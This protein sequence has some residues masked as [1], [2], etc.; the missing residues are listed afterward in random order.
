MRVQALSFLLGAAIFQQTSAQSG[1]CTSE[2]PTSDAPHKNIWSSLTEQE[3]ESVT[4]FLS[5]K[6][7]LTIASPETGTRVNS[8]FEIELLLPNKTDILL[9]LNGQSS[10]EPKRYARATVAFGTPDEPYFQEYMVGPLPATSSMRLQPLTYT[11]NNKNLGKTKASS[12]ILPG[13]DIGGGVLNFGASIEDITRELWNS[14]IAEGGVN[15]RTQF[16]LVTEGKKTLAWLEFLG[17]PTSEFDGPTVLPLGVSVQLDTTNRDPLEWVATGWFCMGVFYSSTEKFR[18]AVFSPGFKKPPPNVDGPWLSLDQRGD[19]LPF[20]DLPPPV[21]VSPGKKRFTI[22]AEENHVSWMDFSFFIA[23][24]RSTGV[25]LFDIQYKGKRVIYELALQEALSQYAGSDPFQAQTNFFDTLGGMGAA[26]VP[27]V[28]GYD[29]PTYATYINATIAVGGQYTEKPGTICLF[30]YDAGFPI[31]RHFNPAGYTSAAKNIYFTVRFVCTVGNYDYM[32]DYQFFL[33]GSIE[34]HVRASGYI[35]AAYFANNEDYGFHIHDF[36]SGS[37]HD[38]VITF[39]ADLDIL[40][41]ENSVQKVEFVADKA[42]YPWTKGYRNTFR[43]DKSFITNESKS[44]LNWAPN[45]AAIYAIV[46]KDAPNNYGEYP[47][48]RIRKAAGA[49]HL[50]Q[51]SSTSTGSAANY[52]TH[53]LYITRQKDSEP[54]AADPFNGHDTVDPLVDFS[55]FFDKE[56]LDQEDLVAWFNLGMHHIPHTG[57]LPNTVMTSA[58]SAIRIEPFNY[59]EGDPSVATLQQVRLTHESGEVKTFGAREANCSVDL[60]GLM[61]GA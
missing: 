22:D 3:L 56:S 10:A 38:H 34:V 18:K 13:Q 52:A 27:L 16:P 23:H 31:R 50:T 40:G 49:S 11:F 33:D 60:G 57:D 21:P 37:M 30:E 28:K 51:T 1:S 2:Q 9:W 54:R 29:C 8:L 25:N 20:D 47:G 4:S 42:K 19:V 6:L 15:L 24:T 43:A 45:D 12:I 55:K 61:M 5:G 39:K 7:N 53:D 35:S 14:T 58:H 36:L 41:T 44:K 17:M 32:F 26:L 59:L 46:N 48:Y